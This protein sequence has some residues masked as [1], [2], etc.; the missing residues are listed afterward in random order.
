MT[1][2]TGDVRIHPSFPGSAGF[3][4][5]EAMLYNDLQCA[6]ISEK[7][8][9]GSIIERLT[10]SLGKKV[11]LS[12]SGS[13]VFCLYSTRKEAVKAESLIRRSVPARARKRWKIFVAQTANF[14]E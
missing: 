3:G 8:V 4:V 11:V 10:A 12:G 13:S 9:L 5:T 1:G 7:K 2:H 14:K 6:A